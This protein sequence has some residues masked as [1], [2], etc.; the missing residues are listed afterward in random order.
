[1]TQD[2]R[3]A[4]IAI[5]APVMIVTPVAGPGRA[6]I[7]VFPTA[8]ISDFDPNQSRLAAAPFVSAFKPAGGNGAAPIACATKVA[9]EA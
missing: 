1:M 6:T 8:F 5:S 9:L 2:P 7:H 4:R 3:G